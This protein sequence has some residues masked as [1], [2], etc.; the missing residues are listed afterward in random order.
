MKHDVGVVIP[1]PLIVG[2]LPMVVI[3]HRFLAI[4]LLV[5][6]PVV[7]CSIALLTS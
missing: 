4:G 2:L 5:A 1:P 3:V 6:I 7:E